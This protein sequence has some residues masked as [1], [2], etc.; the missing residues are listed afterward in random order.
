MRVSVQ[1]SKLNQCPSHG[2]GRV[3]SDIHRGS[4]LRPTA[5]WRGLAH[6]GTQALITIGR[7]RT[8][9]PAASPPRHAPD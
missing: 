7:L 8:A 2:K 6:P 4:A 5:A 9:A 3:L 1:I